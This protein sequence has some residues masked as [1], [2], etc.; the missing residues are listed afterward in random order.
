MEISGLFIKLALPERRDT[1]FRRTERLVWRY[2][3]KRGLAPC[4]FADDERC[5]EFGSDIKI[6]RF[7]PGVSQ[8]GELH[9]P[10]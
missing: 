3:D 10:P 7:R 8:D 5:L 9:N 6:E 1:A 2:L 4:A